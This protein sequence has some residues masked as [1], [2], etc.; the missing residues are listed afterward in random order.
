[1]L[2][3]IIPSYNDSQNVLKLISQLPKD[4]QVI[5]VESGDMSYARKVKRKKMLVIKGARGRAQQMNTGA[6]FAKGKTLLFLH[7]DCDICAL[8]FTFSGMWGAH[9]VKF[10]SK[11][12]YF[13]FIEFT[14]N[15]RASLGLPFGDQ[16]IYVDK[17]LFDKVGGFSVG[18]FEDIDLSLQLHK[19]TPPFIIREKIIT[20]SRRFLAHG[21]FKTHLL[22]GFI[23]I[24]YLLGCKKYAHLAYRLIT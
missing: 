8:T 18:G 9:R 22:M 3:I 10:N 24:S 2:S 15:I 20:S 1:M 6:S 14:S 21:I 5:V 19:E 13:R 17:K 11:N 16:G 7:A 4:A 12:P 23:L